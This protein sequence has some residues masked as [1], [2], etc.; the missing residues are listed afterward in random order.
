MAIDMHSVKTKFIV[1]GALVLLV[2]MSILGGASYYYANKY[3]TVSEV[4][5]MQL[6][7]EIYTNK[8]E[9]VTQKVNDYL[10]TMAIMDSVRNNVGLKTDQEKQ[11]MVRT[12]NDCIKQLGLLELIT[13][14]R[15]D[16]TGIR[17]DGT[18]D[19]NMAG[20]DYFK[21]VSQT[22]KPYITNIMISRATGKRSILFVVPVMVNGKMEGMFVGTYILDQISA[23]I[24]EAKL[25]ET[26]YGFLLDDEG[27]VIVNPA[28]P[29][30]D[31]QYNV[32]D[33]SKNKGDFS[34]FMDDGRMKEL[35]QKAINSK[36]GVMGE[37][38]F[39][40]DNPKMAMFTAIDLIGGHKW[41]FALTAPKAEVMALIDNLTKVMISI[42][43]ICLILTMFVLM[44]FGKV[45]TKP[46][47]A[48]TGH[49][50]ELASGNLSLKKLPVT[51]KD[52]FGVL[53]DSCNQMVENMKML[54]T[55][56]QH[57]TEQV[58]SSSEELTASAE[59]CA[60]VTSQ[61]AE[62]VSHVAESANHQ[63]QEVGNAGVVIENMS[64]AITHVAD[65]VQKSAEQAA[66]AA[67]SAT[68]G[69][70][71]INKAVSQ[72][73]NIEITVNDSATMV[74]TLGQRSQEIGQI[75][76]TITGI[77]GQ[78]NLL[79]LNAAIE[80]ARAGESG[81]GFAV[82]AEEVRKLAEQSETAAK[83]IAELISVIQVDT[84]KAVIAM[85]KGTQEVKV[86]AGVV[87]DAGNSFIDIVNLIQ[88]VSEQITAVTNAIGGVHKGM[89]DIVA[90]AGAVDAK[91]KVIAGETQTVS[92]ATEEQ[93]A[94]MQEIASSSQCLARLA[95]ELQ[96]AT[97][98]FK[99]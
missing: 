15:A 27:M 9:G 8:V 60:M 89:S 66:L 85:Q 87:N 2:A 67:K 11:I 93:A 48:M 34:K 29:D 83:Q 80:A 52:E 46:I 74:T 69:R 19:P 40:S 4:E 24:K 5:S 39:G 64:Q 95:Q 44:Y 23:Y 28:Y 65:N 41:V 42:T 35:Y 1:F 58:A 51:S 33:R 54:I 31:G 10:A 17:P 91:S 84:D 70:E 78:T 79:A 25:K 56:I 94:S 13:Y 88:T 62:S 82:V 53:S 57:T 37:Y 81:R 32:V 71:F 75:V 38:L 68:D 77:A 26:G 86:G 43:V 98:R 30:L 92:A 90:S 73:N 36:T 12:L 49:L 55:R 59:Q 63:A 7:T 6:T 20:R 14:V 99:L 45:F 18:V 21:V 61:V 47:A 76:D 22:Q 3:L 16:G 72:M 97:S 96:E 50:K